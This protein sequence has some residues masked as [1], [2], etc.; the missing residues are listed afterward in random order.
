MLKFGEYYCKVIID[1]LYIVPGHHG[2]FAASH[3]VACIGKIIQYQIH[4]K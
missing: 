3:A 2:R 4:R 1:I